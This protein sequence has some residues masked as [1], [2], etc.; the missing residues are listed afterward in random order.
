MTKRYTY[1]KS[2]E[3]FNTETFHQLFA[4]FTR[5]SWRFQSS[6]D[7]TAKSDRRTTKL[8]IEF[9]TKLHIQK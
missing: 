2:S 8:L 7:K 5:V 6:D 4:R 1:E 9:E 3:I